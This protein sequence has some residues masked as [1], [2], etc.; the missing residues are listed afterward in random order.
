MKTN[1]TEI[2]E[3]TAAET[4]IKEGNS[5]AEEQRQKYKKNNSGKNKKL[6]MRETLLSRSRKKL[7]NEESLRAEEFEEHGADVNASLVIQRS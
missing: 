1:N 3:Q 6:K 5:C 2:T 4:K 7:E